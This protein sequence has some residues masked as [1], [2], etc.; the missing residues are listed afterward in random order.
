MSD[1]GWPLTKEKLVAFA[2]EHGFYI[3]PEVTED[4]EKWLAKAN[5]LRHCP[6]TDRRPVCPCP[7]SLEDVKR[8][9]G[10]CVCT[11]FCGEHYIEKYGHLFGGRQAFLKP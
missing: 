5:R 4:W 9:R 2:R 3:H 8:P 1:K 11:L 6:C 7:E 10:C